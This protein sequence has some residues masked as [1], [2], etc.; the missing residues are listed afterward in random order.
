MALIERVVAT[1]QPIAAQKG[2][3]LRVVRTSAN[4]RSDPV[5]LER[6]LKN[7]LTNAIRYTERG[8][9]VIGCRRLAPGR[10]RIE[11]VDSGVG[12]PTE[13]QDHIFEEYY[14]L[15]GASAQGLGLG[16]PIVK[17]LGDLLGH[18]VAVRSV[19]RRGSIFSIE[20]ERAL[21]AEAPLQSAGPTAFPVGV[22]VALVDDDVEIRNSMRLLL[23]E[24]GCE[25]ISG[26][27]LE[28]VEAKLQS[29]SVSPDALIV[30]Y[31]LAGPMTGVEVIARLR[32]AY[33]ASLPAMIITGTTNLPLVQSRTAGISIVTKPVAPGKLRAFLSHV[34]LAESSARR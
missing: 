33:G 7:L 25:L 23:E 34:R 15:D 19:P 28:D 8:R 4:V 17:S 30:D 11:I 6:V 12:I 31:R 2:L 26:A 27:N 5:L 13:E 24:W 20:L 16:L 29:Q 18:K 9:I 21:E 10:L 3:E 1:E 22:R 32:S 14:Q